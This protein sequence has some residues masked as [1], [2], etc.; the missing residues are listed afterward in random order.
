MRPSETI[1][2]NGKA[3]P[4]RS[5]AGLKDLILILQ[6]VLSRA[7]KFV[8][9]ASRKGRFLTAFKKSL[10]EKSGE[11]PFLD[12]FSGEFE[13]R[14]GLI[15]FTGAADEKDFAK[16]I[17]ECLRVAV[18]HLEEELSNKKLFSLK[19]KAEIESSLEPHRETMKQLGIDSALSSFFR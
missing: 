18:S 11:Y 16:G 10:L 2:E 4:D 19:L 8:D 1:E 7:E 17:A 3:S 14:D 5:P 13:Y 6:E 9:G 12:P 15:R